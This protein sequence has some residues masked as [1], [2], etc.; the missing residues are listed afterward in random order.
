M[1]AASPYPADWPEWVPQPNGLQ[2]TRTP[3]RFAKADCLTTYNAGTS[4]LNRRS[5]VNRYAFHVAWARWL[6]RELKAA[7]ARTMKTA[8]ELKAMRQ[9]LK[10]EKTKPRTARTA[11]ASKLGVREKCRPNIRTKARRCKSR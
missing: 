1:P 3:Y 9:K 6:A 11:G 8:R 10:P 5:D 4:W 2:E 7:D